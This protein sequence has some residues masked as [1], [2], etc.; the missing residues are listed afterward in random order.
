MHRAFVLPS[1][2]G[3]ALAAPRSEIDELLKRDEVE[4]PGVYLLVGTDPDTGQ[5]SA[6]VS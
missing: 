6:Y 2:N 5:A 4:K 1:W 3:K